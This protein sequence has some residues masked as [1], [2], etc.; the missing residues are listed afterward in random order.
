[1]RSKW[2]DFESPLANGIRAF[3]AYKRSLGRKYFTEEKNLRLLDSYLIEQKIIRTNNITPDIIDS[4]L[5]SRPRKRTRSYNDLVGIL[6]RFFNW[7]V[8]QEIIEASPVK[9]H[10]K[11]QT[12][13]QIPYIFD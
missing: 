4:F 10:R 12:D 3:I 5:A 6:K 7:L 9:A 11:R 13:N 1:M 2:I 8:V